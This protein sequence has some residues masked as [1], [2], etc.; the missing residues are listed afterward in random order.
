MTFLTSQISGW[1]FL[2]P[3]ERYNILFVGIP[4]SSENEFIFLAFWQFKKCP[5]DV[6][7]T[8]F[9]PHAPESTIS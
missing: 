9:L 6:L 4:L 1:Q 7:L 5:P 2:P 3:L 8:D